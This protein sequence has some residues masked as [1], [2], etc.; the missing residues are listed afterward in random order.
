MTF[1]SCEPLAALVGGLADLVLSSLW[2]PVL[3]DFGQSWKVSSDLK[4][5]KQR[6]NVFLLRTDGTAGKQQNK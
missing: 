3:T 2:A 6:M 5:D 4:G 1:P